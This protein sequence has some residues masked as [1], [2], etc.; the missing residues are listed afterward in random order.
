MGYTNSPLVVYTK[1]SPNHSGQRTHSIDRITPHCVV[2]QCSVETLGNIFAPTSRQASCNYGIGVDG[3]VGMYVKEKN[4]SWCSSSNANDQ[5]AVTIE[6]ASDTTHPYAFKNVVYKKLITLCVDICKRN[7]KTKLLWLGNKNKTLNYSPKSDEMILTVHR[8]FANKSCP[9]DWLYNRLDDL[10]KQVTAQ[11]GGTQTATPTVTETSSSLYRVQVGA[12]KNQSNA[13]KTADKMKAKGFDTMIVKSG[14]LYKVQSG[15]FSKK[16]NAEAL[17]DKLKAA[18][19]EAVIV[20]GTS[21][22]TTS[23]SPS[24][25]STDVPKTI[26]DF[27]KGK[28]FNDYAVAGIMGNLYYESGLKPT[29]LQNTYEK[30]LGMTDDQYTKAVDDGSYTN[31]VKDS[32]GYGLAQWTYWSRKEGLLKAAQAAKK[33]IGDLGVQLDYLWKELQGYTEVM[34]VL[35]AAT[36]VKA[37]SDII[38]TQFERPADQSD[39]AKIKRA[40]CGQ[41]YYDKYAGKTSSTSATTTPAKTDT[42]TPYRVKVNTLVLNVRQKPTTDSAVTTQIRDQGVYTIV[43]KSNGKGASKWGKLKSGAGWI[44]LDYAKKL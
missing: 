36:T 17:R 24:T 3:R 8:W 41:T 42:F 26:W 16:A 39:N 13:Q 38:L 1:L 33:S 30:S 43:G 12:Y 20:G 23:E 10:A 7:G 4:R 14:S 32:A 25:A 2:G 22:A 5:R 35:K 21:T 29:N 27:L 15:A 40:N 31:F 34:K 37:A 9:G 44:S 6:C 18:G 11:L 28:G 19:F